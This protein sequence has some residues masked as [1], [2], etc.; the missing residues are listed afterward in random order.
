MDEKD[1]KDHLHVAV[2]AAQLER[3]GRL[4]WIVVSS[5]LTMADEKGNDLLVTQDGIAGPDLPSVARSIGFHLA[6]A[7]LRLIMGMMK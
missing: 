3:Q 2:V 7:K 5:V 1:P 4:R 6:S